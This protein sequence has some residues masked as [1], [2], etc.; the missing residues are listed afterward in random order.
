MDLGIRGRQAIVCAASRGLGRACAESLAR[1]GCDLTLIART[2]GPLAE[3]AAEITARH[4]VKVQTIAA[5]VNTTAGREAL[6]AACER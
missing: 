3:A 6:L 2:P 4:G 1:E 5:D